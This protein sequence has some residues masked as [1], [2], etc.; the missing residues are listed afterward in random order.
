MENKEENT[1][2]ISSQTLISDNNINGNENNS[3]NTQ[4]LTIQINSEEININNND[5]SLQSPSS[6]L[7]PIL[8]DDDTSDIPD[9]FQNNTNSDSDNDDDDEDYGTSN[10][11][12]YK[13]IKSNNNGIY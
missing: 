3:D 8:P 1:D 6:S 10:F 9:N 2:T 13:K 11:L 5:N 4:P 7:N 12:L